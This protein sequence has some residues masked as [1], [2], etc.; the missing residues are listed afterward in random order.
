[1][2]ISITSRSHGCTTVNLHLETIAGK[3][4]CGTLSLA[5]VF[6]LSTRTVTG[7]TVCQRHNP[8][9][10][11]PRRTGQCECGT[12][13]RGNARARSSVT[14]KSG[15]WRGIRMATEW[16]PAQERSFLCGTQRLSSGL[17]LRQ[18]ISVNVMRSSVE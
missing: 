16:L 3:Y 11:Q 5:R 8:S 14:I 13:Q 15:L 4:W 12:L 17:I 2:P 10:H 6:E 9:W 18:R 1:M 7:S